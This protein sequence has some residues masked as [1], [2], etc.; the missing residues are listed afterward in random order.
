MGELAQVYE[1]Y[2]AAVH[3]QPVAVDTL[4]HELWSQKRYGRWLAG[5]A[6][7]DT[8]ELVETMPTD[9]PVTLRERL[10]RTSEGDAE[11]EAM[12]RTNVRSAVIETIFNSGH[13]ARTESTIA[14]DG[15]W[16]QHGQ[17]YDAVYRNTLEVSGQSEAMLA[18]SEIEALNWHRMEDANRA[19]MLQDGYFV[20]FSLVPDEISVQE[21]KKNFFASNLSLAV[22]ATSKEGDKIVT[23]TAFLAGMETFDEDLTLSEEDNNLRLQQAMARR[24]DISTVRQMY[25]AWGIS[26][27]E[28]LSPKDLLAKPL[29]VPKEYMPSGVADLARWYDQIA[30]RGTFFGASLPPH[31][32]ATFDAFCAVR[33]RKYDS[34]TENVFR[35]LLAASPTFTEDFQ[36]N[37]RMQYLVKKHT[38]LEVTKNSDIDARIFGAETASSVMA[39]REA[40]ARGD[41]DAYLMHATFVLHNAVTIACRIMS[42][43]NKSG[44]ESLTD[45]LEGSQEPG[46]D[47]EGMGL[48]D[49]IRCIKCKKKS[50]PKD[51]IT[52]N[53]WRCPHCEY[54][55]DI[56]T[57]K[58]IK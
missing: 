21:V 25:R 51:V 20:E 46:N 4:P 29:V 19:G 55:V 11:A 18:W 24:F 1:V 10:C 33:E 23:K 42:G 15:T 38:V 32:Y 49:K 30:D 45:I 56:C 35:E 28:H 40:Y 7:R 14:P 17:T 12:V 48:P 27:A 2:D 43:K 6:L 3:Q 13:I 54:E 52:P 9:A 57:G 47:E 34:I 36:A 39:A 22:R 58:E 31:D 5:L 37:Q 53:S 16:T 41:K 44:L 50:L 26:G 8:V